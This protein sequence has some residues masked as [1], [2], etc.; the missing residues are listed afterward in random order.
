MKTIAKKAARL[1]MDSGRYWATSPPLQDFLI[2]HVAPITLD[3]AML[4]R[5][6]TVRPIWRLNARVLCQPYLFPH[7][8]VFWFGRLESVPLDN[9]L[10]RHLHAG[11]TFLDVGANCGQYTTIASTLV[12]DKGRVIAFEP[13]H[14]MQQ[15]LAT[16]VRSQQLKNVTL[17]NVA[18]GSAASV[19]ELQFNRTAPGCSTLRTDLTVTGETFSQPCNLVR[20]DDVL[21]GEEIKGNTILKVDVEGHELECLRG[22]QNSLKHFV[23]FALIEITPAWIGGIRGVEEMWSIMGRAGLHGHLITPSGEIG[24]LLE[25]SDIPLDEQTDV[26]FCRNS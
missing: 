4:S 16:H 10:R 3:P 19:G 12:Q 11:D 18:L 22:L 13:S 1:L 21:N 17:H 5:E 26:V 15:L 7:M 24:A 6:Y 14:D 20:G 25:A 2:K 9:F 8:R 23:K